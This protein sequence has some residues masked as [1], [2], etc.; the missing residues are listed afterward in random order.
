MSG[1]FA[2]DAGRCARIAKQY[3]EGAKALDKAQRKKGRILF[4]PTL[5]LAGHG[6]E[7]MLKSCSYLN[8]MESS[9]GKKMGHDILALWNT[10]LC[11]PVRGNVFANAIKVTIEARERG[12]YRGV[13]D[14]ADVLPLI[15]EYVTALGRLHGSRPYPLRYPTEVEE[16]APSTPFL[17]KS[18]WRTANDL[19]NQ[20][21][22]FE[23]SRFLGEE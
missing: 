13:P 20:P 12:T 23:L 19:V 17:V 14:D 5:S 8:G 15:E 16:W 10:D 2:T 7:L 18:L 6:L 3:L 9:A 22:E 11:E 1:F 21:R 4:L